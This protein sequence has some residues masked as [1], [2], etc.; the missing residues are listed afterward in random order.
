MSPIPTRIKW[1]DFIKAV[2]RIAIKNFGNYKIFPKTGSA[3]RIELFKNIN[4]K[5]PCEI[6]VVHEDSVVWS[7][8]LKKVCSALKV[9]KEYFQKIVDSL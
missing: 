7:G 6:C 4:D 9:S 8:D 3:R 5:I 1:K 2:E